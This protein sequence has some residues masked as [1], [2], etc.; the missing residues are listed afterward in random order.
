MAFSRKISLALSA[1][2]TMR[3][4]FLRE[5]TSCASASLSAALSADSVSRARRNSSLAAALVSSYFFVISL[6]FSRAASNSPRSSSSSPRD[7]SASSSFFKRSHSPSALSALELAASNA[8]LKSMSDFSSSA[9]S[10]ARASSEDAASASNFSALAAASDSA[11]FAPASSSSFARNIDSNASTLASAREDVPSFSTIDFFTRLS[12]SAVD[13][14]FLSAAFKSSFKPSRSRAAAARASSLS[15]SL[16]VANSHA[17]S[18]CSVFSSSSL[19]NRF[20]S[21]STFEYALDSRPACAAAALSRSPRARVVSNSLVVASN[22]SLSSRSTSDDDA[23]DDDDDAS[24]L[25]TVTAVVVVVVSP[26]PAFALAPAV[27]P[28]STSSRAFV[29]TTDA[30]DR[31]FGTNAGASTRNAIRSPRARVVVSRRRRASSRRRESS[32]Q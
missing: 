3:S 23:D 21:S 1:R 5:S 22:A 6:A 14:A 20:T 2:E 9:D 13:N 19:V 31:F 26:V 10:R 16:I 30:D 25:V 4:T 32:L 8:T 18:H 12:S 17:C 29:A 24:P 15:L 11:V 7:D 28:A 27:A